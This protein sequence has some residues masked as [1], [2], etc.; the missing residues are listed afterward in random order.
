VVQ[1]A[2][3][4]STLPDRAIVPTKFVIVTSTMAPALFAEQNIATVAAIDLEIV[5]HEQAIVTLKLRRNTHIWINQLPVEL[6]S[7]ILR[8]SRQDLPTNFT[9]NV[10]FLGSLRILSSVCHHWRQVALQNPQ[11]WSII[12]LTLSKNWTREILNRSQNTLITLCMFRKQYPKLDMALW[13]PD[14]LRDMTKIQVIHLRELYSSL[15]DDAFPYFTKSAPFLEE[16]SIECDYSIEPRI[17]HNLW[18]EP[19]PMFA[20]QTPRLRHVTFNSWIDWDQPLLSNLT[21]F[22]VRNILLARRP[23]LPKLCD[24]LRAMPRLEK[25]WLDH[26]LPLSS[27]S[28]ERISCP[29]QPV[30]LE[31][32][33]YVRLDDLP[34][35][36]SLLLRYIRFPH[37]ARLLLHTPASGTY[38]QGPNNAILSCVRNRFNHG[39]TSPTSLCLRLDSRLNLQVYSSLPSMQPATPIWPDLDEPQTSEFID[40]SV[41]LPLDHEVIFSAYLPTVL[42]KI[43]PVHQLQS[44]YLAGISLDDPHLLEEV[45]CSSPLHFITLSGRCASTFIKALA[46]R[47]IDLNESSEPH[48]IQIRSGLSFKDNIGQGSVPFL[49]H[50]KWLRFYRVHFAEVSFVPEDLVTLFTRRQDDGLS[51]MQLDI[52]KSPHASDLQYGVLQE[53]S[54]VINVV[55]WDEDDSYDKPSDDDDSGSDSE[56][57]DF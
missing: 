38:E 17:L 18:Q 21:S 51:L 48:G 32:L 11:F 5:A 36:V 41:L 53:L 45:F 9:E 12:P 23:K 44:L 40:L 20:G 10:E 35:Y 50:L 42:G 25:L 52:Y 34:I 19:I 33:H 57:S 22:T 29:P 27:G 49:P 1:I 6:L 4:L 31:N 8:L 16:L 47:Y 37:T 26:A 56:D 14:L 55:Y 30:S 7:K 54:Q 15:K 46:S 24:I 13:I 3:N 39:A 28:S 43:I 2:G